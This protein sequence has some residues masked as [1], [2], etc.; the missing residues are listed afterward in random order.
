MQEIS[1]DRIKAL[2]KKSEEYAK[3]NNLMLNK[4]KKV[5]E[6]IIKGL[7]RNEDKYGEL[8]CPCRPI[9]QNKEEDKKII[10]PCVY[11]M[12]EIKE[13]GKCHCGLFVKK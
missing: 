6:V 2:T 4:N 9:T 3:R 12:Q 7:L 11:H 10:C 1:E 5:V 13:M 8:Y